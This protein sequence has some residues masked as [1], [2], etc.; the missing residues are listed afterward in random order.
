MAKY[1]INNI[2]ARRVWDSRGRPTVEVEVELDGGAKGIAIAPA[3]ASRG[4]FE[5]IDLRDGGKTFGGWDVTGA[6]KAVDIEIAEVLKGQD[7]REQERLDK[8][9]IELDGTKNK[10]RLGGN[11]TVATSMALA[12]AAAAYEGVPLWQYLRGSADGDVSL[13]LPEI[14]IFG[15]GA[16]ASRRVDVQDFMVIATGAKS[17]REA[18]DWTAE[19]YLSA[20]RIMADAGKLAGVADEGGYWP[21]F[22]TNEEAME[23]LVR[24]IEGAG[25][26]PGQEVSISLDIAASEFGENGKYTLAKDDRE[27][28]SEELC[29]MMVDWM[30]RYP[31]VSI[32]DPLG[33]DDPDGLMK[34][35]WAVGDN[36]QVVGDDALVTNADRVRAAAKD[37][38]CNALLCKPNQAGTLTE[39][40]AAFDAAEKAGMGR[41]VSAR[42]GETE[43]STIVHLAV[44]WGA[45]QLKVGSFTRSERMVKWNEGLRI[46]DTLPDRDGP[47]MPRSAFQWR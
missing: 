19:V 28:S 31:V 26:T 16:H 6:V 41:I 21:D 13:P 20:G 39:A 47:L 29:A 17:F 27:L 4:R 15:G 5:A 37:K 33:E 34:F 38:L 35:T 18:L 3:G 46:A 7:V 14:Q 22:D 2:H 24:A 32:E 44:G 11:A 1:S 8:F 25:F 45:P 12:H 40:K 23:T 10:Q 43:D 42:S 36:A 30:E 9:M